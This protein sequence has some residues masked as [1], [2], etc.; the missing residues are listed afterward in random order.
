MAPA[1]LWNQNISKIAK[2]GL[3]K[4]SPFVE[5]PLIFAELYLKGFRTA[6]A[7]LV[8]LEKEYMEIDAEISSQRQDMGGVHAAAQ[9]NTSIQKQVRILENRLDKVRAWPWSQ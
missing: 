2:P 3:I 1:P 5:S 8:E 9:T 6:Q 4:A 7:R